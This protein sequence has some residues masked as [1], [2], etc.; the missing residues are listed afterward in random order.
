MPTADLAQL[1]ADARDEAALLRRRGVTQL[2]DFADEL[3]S[4]VEAAAED[5]LRFIPERRRGSAVRSSPSCAATSDVGA[6]RP[7]AEGRRR[8]RVPRDHAAP[9][10]AGVVAREAGRRGERRVG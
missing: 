2:A 6:G 1:L 3:V 4:K 9:H 10:D 7:R 8:A 5:Y